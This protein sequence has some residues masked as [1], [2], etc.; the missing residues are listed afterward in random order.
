LRDEA[1]TR[2][3][4][5]KEND[6]VTINAIPWWTESVDE[7]ARHID[8]SSKGLTIAEAAARL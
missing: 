4:R 1:V 6:P 2:A 5:L 3:E 8:S 7:I